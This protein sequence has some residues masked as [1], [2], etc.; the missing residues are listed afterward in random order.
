MGLGGRAG[1]HVQ[2]DL[3]LRYLTVT[4]PISQSRLPCI[5]SISGRI[6]QYDDVA[7][8]RDRDR[9]GDYQY[10]IHLTDQAAPTEQR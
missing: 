9:H 2:Q 4:S 5:C 1:G 10:A 3:F 6:I 8:V 7:Q